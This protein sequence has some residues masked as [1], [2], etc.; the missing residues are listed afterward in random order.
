MNFVM[1]VVAEVLDSAMIN[2]AFMS[3]PMM[4]YIL[5]F[6]E[7]SRSIRTECKSRV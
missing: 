3:M 4:M 6:C 7:D 2:M 5:G 1:R